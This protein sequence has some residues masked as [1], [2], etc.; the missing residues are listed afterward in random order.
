MKKYIFFYFISASTAI[1]N[2]IAPS[3]ARYWADKLLTGG[4]FADFSGGFVTFEAGSLEEAKRITEQDPFVKENILL[5]SEL[6]EWLA[7]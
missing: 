4:P 7:N 5:K 3:H 2:K 6:I 1:I